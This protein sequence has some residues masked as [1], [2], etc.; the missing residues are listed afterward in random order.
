LIFATTS[1]ACLD[2]SSLILINIPYLDIES[3]N[4]PLPECI[5]IFPAA[6]AS[7]AA[8]PNPS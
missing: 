6:S 1:S 8:I 7:N 5:T 3:F 2:K 4:P